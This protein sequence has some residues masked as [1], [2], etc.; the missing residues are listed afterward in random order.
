MTPTKNTS[1]F[2]FFFKKNFL[3]TCLEI[4]LETS[5]KNERIETNVR[6]VSSSHALRRYCTQVN[7]VVTN[8]N[9]GDS[10]A[11]QWFFLWE[12]RNEIATEENATTWSQIGDHQGLL[13]SRHLKVQLDKS[14]IE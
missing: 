2:F 1:F 6:F 11:R 13:T 12:P 7:S 3:K 4:G 10:T 9:K 14:K 5:F 8:A